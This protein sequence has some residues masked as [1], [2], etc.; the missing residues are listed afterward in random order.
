MHIPAHKPDWTLG[1]P[2]DSHSYESVPRTVT[3]YRADGSV[4]SVSYGA[5][6][7]YIGRSQR[8]KTV[9]GRL[10][11]MAPGKYW[12]RSTDYFRVVCRITWTEGVVSR[13]LSNNRR[14]EFVISGSN[15][16]DFY[17]DGHPIRFEDGSANFDSNVINRA[18][19]ECLLKLNTNKTH[20][21]TDLAEAKRSV[22]M[23]ADR[24]HDFAHFLLTMRKGRAQF[25]IS[26]N[27]FS[28][29]LEWQYGWKPLANSLIH[30]VETMKKA[31]NPPMLTS[32]IRTIRETHSGT[33]KP[34]GY[35]EQSA[36]RVTESATC[37]LY[38]QLDDRYRY[39]AQGL[40]LNPLTTAW[41]LVPWSFLV[42]WCLP[43]G[44][45]LE[46]L[47]S[48]AGLKFWDGYETRV[49]EG[50]SSGRR[51]FGSAYTGEFPTYEVE[52]GEFRRA[53][54]D[55]FPRPVP[56]FKSPFS[57]Q[58]VANAIALA[59]TLRKSR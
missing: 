9:K 14:E 5:Q 33:R 53:A 49:I 34:G 47:T 17:I 8:A 22:N 1:D 50:S 29:Y 43:V 13:K 32:A 7:Q 48:T 16:P 12:R 3:V 59:G 35:H 51:T 4:E 37:C 23:V 55:K 18:R 24:F 2:G 20:L 39:A 10:K 31:F 44:N 25:G 28:T 26:K 56:Y 57:T 58:H 38:G 6:N 21:L 54:L 15:R 19:T 45:T 27:F 30:S 52:C 11:L 36:S 46:A 41:E 40:G 42:D